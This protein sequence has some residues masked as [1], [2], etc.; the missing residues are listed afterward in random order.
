MKEIENAKE[1]LNC[2]GK[3]KEAYEKYEKHDAM[4][5]LYSN[6]SGIELVRNLKNPFKYAEKMLEKNNITFEEYVAFCEKAD[7][8]KE[9]NPDIKLNDLL[10]PDGRKVIGEMIAESQFDKKFKPEELE[11]VAVV[12][13]YG[14]YQ[15]VE[16]TQG[17]SNSEII[18]ILKD[19]QVPI[20]MYDSAN[21]RVQNDPS[22]S[23][24]KTHMVASILGINPEEAK[25]N[26]VMFGL[27]EGKM[28][29][30]F[31]KKIKV[32]QDYL[33][34]KVDY[35][36]I[37]RS[38]ERISI[39]ENDIRLTDFEKSALI[40]DQQKIIDFARQRIEDKKDKRADKRKIVEGKYW[41]RHIREGMAEPDDSREIG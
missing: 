39:I 38:E 30:D 40:K 33:Y 4:F 5:K 26:L 11:G 32:D 6:S 27:V 8:L 13:Y 14:L 36:L 3:R 28:L 18:K 12:K 7:K 24:D 21:K 9:K 25:Y 34:S 10:T 1:T 31:D 23:I 16:E 35:D 2:D 37:K 19:Y 41:Q 29:S 17:K 20:G 15:A 22:A